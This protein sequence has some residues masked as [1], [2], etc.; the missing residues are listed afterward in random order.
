MRIED[1]R[2]VAL[3][4]P[5]RE[6]FEISLGEQTSAKNL[7]VVITIDGGVTGYGEGSPIAPVSGETQDA[8]IA[9]A[10]AAGDLLLGE[11]LT[12]YRKL[13]RTVRETFPGAVSATLAVEMALLDAYCRVHEIPLAALFGGGPAAVETDLTIPIIEPDIARERARR[14]V[15]RG[16][17][18]L[19][20]KTGTDVIS[21]VERVEAVRTGAPGVGIKIDANQGWTPAETGHFADACADRGIDLE[22]IEQPVRA[23]DIAGLAR[24]R[25][26]VSV[27]IAADESVFTPADAVRIVREDAAD[28]INV[29]LGK[30]GLLGARDIAAIAEGANLELMIGCMLESALGIHAAAHVVAGTGLFSYVDLDGNL[31]L[32][33]DVADV[34]YGQTIEPVGPGHGIEP[35]L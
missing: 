14:A 21:D 23:D 24:T 17:T 13:V 7:A 15:D 2:V 34:A 29:K 11:D 31:L 12:H 33:E 8:A 1:V 32:A 35:D 25:E 10:R 3:D 19:K 16:F 28:V 5:L 20:I 4:F 6:P 26:T 18:Q 30:S 9:T 27:P 22:L